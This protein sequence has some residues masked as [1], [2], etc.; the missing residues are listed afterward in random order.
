M[1]EAVQRQVVYKRWRGAANGYKLRVE[2]GFEMTERNHSSEIGPFGY[3]DG[4][5]NID[6][7]VEKRNSRDEIV[8]SFNGVFRRLATCAQYGKVLGDMRGGVYSGNR[9]QMMA[10]AGKLEKWVIGGFTFIM[11]TQEEYSVFHRLMSVEKKKQDDREWRKRLM[12]QPR[13]RDESFRFGM[14]RS[15]ALKD[16]KAGKLQGED[17]DK[18]F[19]E[20]FNGFVDGIKE[21]TVG[22]WLSQVAFFPAPDSDRGIRTRRTRKVGEMWFEY[23]VWCAYVGK[24]AK[25]IKEF[26]RYM[27]KTAGFSRKFV[28]KSRNFEVFVMDEEQADGYRMTRI[29]EAQE[30]REEWQ[31][32]ERQR[33]QDI[34]DELRENAET[35]TVHDEDEVWLSQVTGRKQGRELHDWYVW[36]CR[37]RRQVS[38]GKKKFYEW[39]EDAGFT[40]ETKR[41]VLWFEKKG[42]EA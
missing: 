23:S 30:K 6:H 15:V 40:R 18:F 24:T 8:R 16:W 38:M 19:L 25:Y 33:M 35:E 2:G 20:E 13:N 29:M 21:D 17:W 36:W 1:S 11:M 37:E 10:R 4:L 12:M 9:V 27:N 3:K 39:L 41:G 42:G 26:S 32:I 7:L 5:Y 28:E 14:E 31:E 22:E 34:Q